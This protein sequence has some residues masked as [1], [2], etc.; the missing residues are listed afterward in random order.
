MVAQ[1]LELGGRCPWCGKSFQPDYAAVLVDALRDAEAAGAT[2]E[3]ALEKLVELEPAFR[4]DAD[5]VL[6]G[7]R[8]HVGLLS[9]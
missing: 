5:S 4:L 9:R 6:A 3:N 7:I 2:L 1:S 8:D